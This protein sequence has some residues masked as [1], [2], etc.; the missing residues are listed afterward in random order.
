MDQQPQKNSTEQNDSFQRMLNV[1]DPLLLQGYHKF[2]HEVIIQGISHHN[3]TLNTLSN[4]LLNLNK[5]TID[6][7][8]E[9]AIYFYDD[10]APSDIKSYGI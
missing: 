3:F 4:C 5:E 9:K 1:M 7:I 10:R 8:V 6:F 2:L